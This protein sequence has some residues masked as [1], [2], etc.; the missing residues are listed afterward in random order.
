MG[1]FDGVFWITIGSEGP[2]ST[3]S[4]ATAGPPS[5]QTRGHD[6]GGGAPAAVVLDDVWTESRHVQPFEELAVGGTTLLTTRNSHLAHDF[7]GGDGVLAVEKMA[8]AQALDLLG[9]HSA[10]TSPATPTRSLS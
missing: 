1:E 3:P 5:P 10:A 2:T 9:K 4:N 8:E 7:A 6:G